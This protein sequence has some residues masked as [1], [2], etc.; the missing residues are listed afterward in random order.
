MSR[1]FNRNADDGSF[2]KLLDASLESGTSSN[3]KNHEVRVKATIGTILD[4][5]L[6]DIIKER[7][8][9][10]ELLQAPGT[11][12]KNIEEDPNKLEKKIFDKIEAGLTDWVEKIDETQLALLL[13]PDA[14]KSLK[15]EKDA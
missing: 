14:A 8:K 2:N 12:E 10:K 7:K 1:R 15:D 11:S 6:E 4:Q 9:K 3:T 13:N 5:K